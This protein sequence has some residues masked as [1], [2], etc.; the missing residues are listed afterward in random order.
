MK[1]LFFILFYG[2]TLLNYSTA[3]DFDN[4]TPLKSSGPLPSDFTMRTSVKVAK[5][6]S[7]E[8]SSKDK[9]SVKKSK[10]GFLLKSNYMVDELLMSGRVLFGDPVSIYVNKV[11]EK[12]LESSP[13]LKGKL[14]FYCLKSNITNAFTTNQGM[15]FITLGLISQLENEAQLAYI[16]AHEITHYKR[17]HVINSY[18]ESDRVYAKKG[19]YKY[20]NYD[21]NIIRLSNYSKSLELECDSV[22]FYMLEQAGYSIKSALS[23]FDV[24]QFSH[25]PYEEIAFNTSMFETENFKI[26]KKYI[27]DT[28]TPIVFE[29]DTDDSKSSHP[30]I[31]KRR[32]KVKRF[33]SKAK[34]SNTNEYLVSK[35]E[36]ATVRKLC[37]YEAIRLN[38]KNREYVKAFY[39][40]NVL[41]SENPNS[42]FLE[43][44]IGKSL[45]G[46]F[47]YKTHNKYYS[48]T[49]DYED[50]EG[51]ISAL[52]YMFYEMDAVHVGSLA[53][54]QLWRQY[55]K[56]KDE[57]IK[58]LLDDI[59][60]ELI[61]NEGLTFESYKTKI[62]IE[63]FKQKIIDD[64]LKQLE[65]AKVDTVAVSEIEQNE[66]DGE[67]SKYDKLR[68][69][70]EIQSDMETEELFTGVDD[71]VEF[72]LLAFADLVGN[73]KLKSE[74]DFVQEIINQ[75]K[76]DKEAFENRFENLSP[77]KQRKAKRKELKTEG[78]NE[79]SLGANKIIF[80]DPEYF[81]VDERKGVKLVNSEDKKFKFYSQ[82]EKVS[83]ASGLESEILSA[84]KFNSGDAESYNN[85]AAFNDWVGERMDHDNS[86]EKLNIIPSETEYA[87]IA[88]N[89]V[90]TEYISYSGVVI[91]KE[92]KDNIGGTLLYTIIIYPLLPLGIYYAVTP[93]Y[94]SYYY[95]MVYSVKTG[96]KVINKI[97]EMKIKANEG[98]INSFMYQTM[99]DM[100]KE[101]E[102]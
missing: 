29:D 77:H 55:N 30:N 43:K 14:R 31:S 57:N 52:Y 58:L 47:K 93:S 51:Q 91:Y 15:I 19:R 54:S 44:S 101:K 45:Y 8:I 56:N 92:K 95:T 41:L 72:H 35:K 13:E 100:Q 23:V 10:S 81:V 37:R 16:I 82:I 53:V 27:L 42:V 38:L 26:P 78:K 59:I 64:S 22:G 12:V 48:I 76:K 4:Y 49:G 11:A 88:S 79:F 86:S 102:E 25:L 85:L 28:I 2:I 1:C 80:V 40:S 60:K 62:E 89:N 73:E 97:Y 69:I 39:N 17:K 71:N 68:K 3:Q 94:Y 74:F 63:A 83:E 20:N 5:D 84:K 65:L 67:L 24:L 33:M 6:L 32:S 18:V 99:V 75:E 96:K 34:K 90:G 21:D 9:H 50:Y 87:L 46:I 70:K 7:T 61:L 36:F 66:G 98:N